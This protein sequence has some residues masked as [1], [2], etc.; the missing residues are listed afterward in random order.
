MGFQPVG[1][2]FLRAK[3]SRT[4]ALDL[5]GCYLRRLFSALDN[6][7]ADPR[8]FLAVRTSKTATVCHFGPAFHVAAIA[9]PRLING[10][11]AV[12]QTRGFRFPDG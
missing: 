3:Q 10:V 7:G 2:A 8:N 1:N 4:E 6:L 9:D 11:K 12:L 5:G